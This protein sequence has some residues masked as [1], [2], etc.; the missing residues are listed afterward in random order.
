MLPVRVVAERRERTVSIASEAGYR[1]DKHGPNT[2]RVFFVV[3]P[4][5]LCYCIGQ[6]VNSP[7]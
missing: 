2:F 5:G 6:K 7:F 4:D 1:I 3:A